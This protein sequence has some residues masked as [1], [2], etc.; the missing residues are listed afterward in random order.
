MDDKNIYI[1]DKNIEII[2]EL[3]K[4]MAEQYGNRPPNPDRDVVV[5]SSFVIIETGRLKGI[6]L[7]GQETNNPE[8]SWLKA[9]KTVIET[10][11][12]LNDAPVGLYEDMIGFVQ[13][14]SNNINSLIKD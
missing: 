10:E 2:G 12:G 9:N 11:M 5:C 1:N 6:Q 13:H 14:W 4:V 8:E 7:E 3:G